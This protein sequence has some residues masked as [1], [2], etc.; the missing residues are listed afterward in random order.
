M[1]IRP[2]RRSTC[3]AERSDPEFTRNLFGMSDVRL[4]VMVL[5]ESMPSNDMRERPGSRTDSMGGREGDLELVERSDNFVN[6]SG[7]VLAECVYE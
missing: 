5:Y 7:R 4:V 2:R 1:A 3:V 6:E